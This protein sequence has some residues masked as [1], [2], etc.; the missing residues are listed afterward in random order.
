MNYFRDLTKY[1]LF[2]MFVMLS[3]LL[4]KILILRERMMSG[5]DDNLPDQVRR[6]ILVNSGFHWRKNVEFNVQGYGLRYYMCR[7]FSW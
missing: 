2:L 7:E 6:I 3:F 4:L 1:G 5:D